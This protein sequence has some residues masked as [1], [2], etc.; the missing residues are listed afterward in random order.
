MSI[1]FEEPVIDFLLLEIEFEEPVIEF[2]RPVIELQ[3][4]EIEFRCLVTRFYFL[5]IKEFF[6]RSFLFP[7]FPVPPIAYF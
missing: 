2:Y 4:D 5:K 6:P 7:K 3:D 1:E